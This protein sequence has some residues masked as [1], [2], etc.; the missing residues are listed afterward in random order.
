MMQ[1]FNRGTGLL[2]IEVRCS[3]PNGDPDAESERPARGDQWRVAQLADVHRHV[4]RRVRHAAQPI[5]QD[6]V[7]RHLRVLGAEAARD[8]RDVLAAEA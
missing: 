6:E 3:I 4:P 7:E 8:G 2:I 5:R 1:V